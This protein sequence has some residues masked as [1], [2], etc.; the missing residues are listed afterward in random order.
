M[1]SILTATRRPDGYKKLI[2]ELEEKM[3]DLIGEYVAFIEKS[4]SEHYLD[5]KNNPKIKLIIAPDN[6]IFNHGF[7]N[8]YNMLIK[9]STQKYCLMIFDTDTI[10]LNKEQF[11][12]DLGEDADLYIF[13]MYMQRG[14]V[15]EDKMQLYK[16]DLLKFEGAVHE[17]QVFLREPKIKQIDSFKIIHQNAVDTESQNLKKTSD[18]FIILEKTVEGSDSDMRNLL[19]ESLAWKIVNG[20]GIHRH[21]GWFQRHYE[22]NKPIIDW[23]YE[24]AKKIWE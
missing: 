16:K 8:L 19:Y 14:D 17:N 4:N 9:T 11:A 24:R 7:D 23:Y 3:G 10:E 5:L 2:T 13:K 12:K 20:N 18:N 15:W 22:V 6:Y 21:K 1:I